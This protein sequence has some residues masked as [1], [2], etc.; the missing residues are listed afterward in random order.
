MLQQDL[1]PEQ[2][3]DSPACEFRLCLV[4]RAEYISDPYADG[5]DISP[6]AVQDSDLLCDQIL[7]AQ[8]EGI[9]FR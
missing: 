3:Q 6:E 7:A 1:Q 9:E 4:A 5:G 2:Y 8:E